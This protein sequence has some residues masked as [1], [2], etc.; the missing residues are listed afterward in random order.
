MEQQQTIEWFGL[1]FVVPAEWE[2]V[3]HSVNEKTGYLM[4]VDRHRQRLQVSWT[5]CETQPDVGRI[6]DDFRSRDK[7]RDPMAEFSEQFKS[8]KWTGYCCSVKGASFTRVGMYDKKCGRWIDLALPWPAGR[9]EDEE[10]GVLDSFHSSDITKGTVRWRAF[11]LDCEVASAFRLTQADVKPARARLLFEK[12]KTQA[13]FTRV[14]MS[15][16]WFDG[17]LENF[18]RREVGDMKGEY[19]FRPSGK[20]EACVFT[21]QEK[22]FHFRWLAGNR[23]V[24]RDLAWHCPSQHAVF[25]VMT[26]GSPKNG[27]VPDDFVVHCA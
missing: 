20:H 6:F 25:D 3:K 12:G 19:A 13:A 5:A 1:R 8:N 18:L 17:H 16:T 4:L 23:H 7:S 22:R 26:K 14:G 2:I 24:R 10:N 21:G 27:A 11:G 15:E 9:D